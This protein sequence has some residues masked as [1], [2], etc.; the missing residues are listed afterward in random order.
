MADQL[1][2][3]NT[4]VPAPTASSTGMPDKDADTAVAMSADSFSKEV[5]AE[6]HRRTKAIK[7]SISR[8]DSSFETIAFNLHW[9]HANQAYKSDGYASIS[10]YASDCFGCQKSTCYSLIAV[11]DRF[12]GR[13]GNGTLKESFDPRVKGYSVSKLSLMVNLT[14]SEIDSLNPSMSVRDIKK[15][16]KGLEGKALPEL[17]EGGG[18]SPDGG[19]GG[20]TDADSTDVFDGFTKCFDK[21][22]Y[23]GKAEKFDCFFSRV[24]KQYPKAVIEVSC[25]VLQNNGT[26]A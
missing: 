25:R 6:F 23:S 16:V 12:A 11:V 18:A 21:D 2:E 15:F 1:F 13:D 20:V 7:S 5:L 26:K 22:D 8:I 3:N 19:G 14:D 9:I 17:P 24:F 4:P 10:E